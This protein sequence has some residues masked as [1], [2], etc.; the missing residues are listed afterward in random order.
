[1]VSQIKGFGDQQRIEIIKGLPCIVSI[2]TGCLCNQPSENAHVRSRK[3][4]GR[5]GDIVPLCHFHHRELH[6]LGIST[7]QYKYD[8]DLAEEAAKISHM[9]DNN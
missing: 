5:E 7:F 9:V 4:G 1:M 8:L 3:A 2:R 6:Q